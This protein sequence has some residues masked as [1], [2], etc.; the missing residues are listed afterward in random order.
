[1]GKTCFFA[2]PGVFFDEY[3]IPYQE[4]AEKFSLELQPDNYYELN[5][6]A[7]P[8]G[9]HVWWKYDIAFWQKIISIEGIFLNKYFLVYTGSVVSLT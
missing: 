8:T 5:N 3:K 1:M 6:R 9:C 2:F 4:N 7:V